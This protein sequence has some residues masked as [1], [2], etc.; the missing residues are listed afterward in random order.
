MLGRGIGNIA[1]G[2][3]KLAKAMAVEVGSGGLLHTF[4]GYLT[5]TGAS[6]IGIGTIQIAGA[7]SPKAQEMNFSAN[8]MAVGTSGLALGTLGTGGTMRQAMDAAMV[9]GILGGAFISGATGEMGSLV[10]AYDTVTSV[11]DLNS[12]AG[13]ANCRR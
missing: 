6:N 5:I 8:Y 9:E 10:D 13:P 4:A 1:L 2:S 11:A 12:P 3:K 7:F